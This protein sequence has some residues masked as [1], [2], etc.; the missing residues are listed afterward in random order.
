M[1]PDSRAQDPE[2]DTARLRRAFGL[3]LGFVL[4]IWLLKLVEIGFARDLDRFG[5]FQRTAD[6]LWG[7]LWGPLIHGAVSHA[8]ANT[9]PLLV[10]GT[11]LL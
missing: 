11:L 6:C 5:V 3:S 4:A 8:F 1:S 2:T 10:L 9:A 7:I